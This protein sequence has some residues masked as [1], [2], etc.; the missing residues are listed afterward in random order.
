[1]TVERQDEWEGAAGRMI[2]EPEDLSVAM[3]CYLS[4]AKDNYMRTNLRIEKGIPGTIKVRGFFLV[5]IAR[6]L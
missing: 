1:L 2:R 6:S 5:K 3:D 4:A